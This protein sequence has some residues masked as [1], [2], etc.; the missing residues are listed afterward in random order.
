MTQRLTLG[1]LLSA[2]TLSVTLALAAA[3]KVRG[4]VA[5]RVDTYLTRLV[6]FG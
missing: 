3:D 5:T 4:E 6:P 2:T 1:V